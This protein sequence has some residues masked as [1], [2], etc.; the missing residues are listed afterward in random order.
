MSRSGTGDQDDVA[1]RPQRAG[2]DVSQLG[3]FPAERRTRRGD[4]QLDRRASAAG[5]HHRHIDLGQVARPADPAVPPVPD[6]ARIRPISRPTSSPLGTTSSFF[7][8]DGLDGGVALLMMDPPE[9]SASS[10]VSSATW[11]FSESSWLWSEVS[12]CWAVARCDELLGRLPTSTDQLGRRRLQGA[13]ILD[14]RDEI[15]LLAAAVVL[16]AL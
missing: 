2:E 10:A 1:A 8:L 12:C 11:L 5:H 15:W 3:E 13:L 4:G 6:E 7:G 16:V 14:C 9:G